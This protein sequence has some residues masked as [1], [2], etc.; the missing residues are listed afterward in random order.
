MTRE[1]HDPLLPFREE[2]KF[3]DSMDVFQTASVALAAAGA[4]TSVA[5]SFGLTIR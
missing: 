1:R 3:A 2:A 5:P 4:V